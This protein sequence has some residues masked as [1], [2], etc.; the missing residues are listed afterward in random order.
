MCHFVLLCV[1]GEESV[2]ILASEFKALKRPMWRYDGLILPLGMEPFASTHH[3]DCGTDVGRFQRSSTKEKPEG[4]L[5]K[6]LRKRGWSNSRITRWRNERERAAQLRAQDDINRRGTGSSE[7][8]D[9]VKLVEKAL[10]RG[11]TQMGILLHWAD[12]KTPK[13]ITNL[14]SIELSQLNP[15]CLT[16]LEE[17][18]LLVVT[19]RTKDKLRI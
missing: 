7:C 15:D 9:I 11:V 4:E 12:P 14:K 17:E 10:G 19:P 1:K 5:E 3:C 6:Q 2:G 16:L 13:L 8:E 18:K